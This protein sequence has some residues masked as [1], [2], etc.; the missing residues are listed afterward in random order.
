MVETKGAKI[1]KESGEKD[2]EVYSDGKSVTVAVTEAIDNLDLESDIQMEHSRHDFQPSSKERK[3]LQ[4]QLG[5]SKGKY[6]VGK[7]DTSSTVVVIETVLWERL[8][9]ANPNRLKKMVQEA[10][11]K[12]FNGKSKVE[13]TSKK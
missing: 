6:R 13:L 3:N 9:K 5:G 8:K 10:H 2:F 1:Q 4:V 7:G 11:K 12:S